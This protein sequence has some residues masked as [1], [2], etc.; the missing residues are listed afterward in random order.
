MRIFETYPP[1]AVVLA[2]AVLV[3]GLIGGLPLMVPLIAGAALM[4]LGHRLDI[5]GI[6]RG[7]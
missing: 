4:A 1:S 5:Y 7:R 2:L 3:V 6:R